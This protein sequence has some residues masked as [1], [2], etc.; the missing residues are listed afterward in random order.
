MMKMPLIKKITWT[1]RR[2]SRSAGGDI[3]IFVVLAVM[4]TFM[5]LPMILA[6]SNAFK[7]LN[8]FFI[9]PPR[10]L[11]RNP[12]MDNFLNL[13]NIMAGS[14]VPLSRY[15]LNSLIIVVFGTVG[16]VVFAS[17]AAYAI[18]K[19]RFP[20]ANIFM[21]MI[22]LSL[23]FAKEVTNIPNYVLIASFGWIDT[24]QAVIVP[25]WGS[26]LGLYLMKNFIDAMIPD[27]VLE[28]ARIDG[29][30]EF[31]IF[32]QLVMP[33]VKPAWLTMIILLF[34]DL[35]KTTGGN[36]I[37]SEELRTLPSALGQIVAGG[38][39][40]QGV[41][42]AVILIMMIVPIVVFLVNQSRILETM[43]TSGMAN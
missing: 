38:V 14:W 20:G 21:G 13:F 1:K 15:L 4:A 8:E 34:Q 17:M 32:W 43:G 3:F 36:F 31:R 35:W 10:L 40:R 30:S 18:S 7:P 16:N 11:V 5:A 37:Y 26:T 33:I 41:G 42:A 27:S 23:M 19:H 24:Y 22:V 29:A 6:V 39:A 25:S 2:V 12:S 28:A 9:F